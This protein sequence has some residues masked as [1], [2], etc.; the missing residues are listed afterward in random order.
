MPEDL[1]TGVNNFVDSISVD[2][3]D[4]N[5][6]GGNMR[7]YPPYCFKDLSLENNMKRCS[8]ILQEGLDTE[9]QSL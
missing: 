5:I 3:L 9:N 7:T 4:I 8:K 1:A 6:S 2:A